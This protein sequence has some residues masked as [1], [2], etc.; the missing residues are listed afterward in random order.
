MDKGSE[1]FMGIPVPPVLE[2]YEVK[3]YPGPPDIQPSSDEDF[4]EESDDFEDK[5]SFEEFVRDTLTD[6]TNTLDDHAQILEALKTGVNT[7]GEM[8][9]GVAQA[10]DQ[11]M[12]EFQKGGLAGLLGTVMGGKK[13][14]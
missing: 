6:I 12:T 1:Q 11:I 10:F 7:I 14:A 2:E 13:N 9:N 8:M 4:E 5:M 3:N